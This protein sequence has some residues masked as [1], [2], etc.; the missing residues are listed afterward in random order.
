MDHW[1]QNSSGAS[2]WAISAKR[3]SPAPGHAKRVNIEV[4]SASSALRGDASWSCCIQIAPPTGLIEKGFEMPTNLKV[5]RVD[6]L[7]GAKFAANAGASFVGLH[8]IGR[9][10]TSYAHIQQFKL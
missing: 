2:S 5:C 10:D 6:T 3:L 1:I 9:W 7:L 4:H 8:A